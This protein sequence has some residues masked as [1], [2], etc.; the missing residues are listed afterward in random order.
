MQASLAREAEL[1]AA[2]PDLVAAADVEGEAD[3]SL[4]EGRSWV[5]AR[6]SPGTASDAQ[7]LTNILFCQDTELP[8]P[9]PPCF[10]PARP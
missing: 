6:E 4:A 9:A 1:A 7:R 10:R 5:G 3:V 2:G 8:H